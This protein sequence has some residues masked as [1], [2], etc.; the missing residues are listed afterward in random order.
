VSVASSIPG[1]SEILKYFLDHKIPYMENNKK[2]MKKDDESQEFNKM[3]ILN[4]FYLNK[5]LLR[6]DDALEMRNN[7]EKKFKDIF[8]FIQA[9]TDSLDGSENI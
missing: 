2:G 9:E 1:K 4:E 3:D 7:Y 5:G 6:S 8:C